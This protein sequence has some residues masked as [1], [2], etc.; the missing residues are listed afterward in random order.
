MFNPGSI[1]EISIQILAFMNPRVF[2]KFL[3]FLD[4]IVYRSVFI[5]FR[6]DTYYDLTV[7]KGFQIMG[8]IITLNC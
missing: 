7:L 5:G 6:S 3:P 1:W 8:Q 4:F 2:D